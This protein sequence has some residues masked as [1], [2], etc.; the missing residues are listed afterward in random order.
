MT[1]A[2]ISTGQPLPPFEQP[3]SAA[4]SQA[5]A[6][7]IDRH[8]RQR[9]RTAFLLVAPL[10]VFLLVA[11]FAPIGSML[12]RS[13]YSP[14]VHNLI[15]QTLDRLAAWDQT[16][17]PPDAMLKT[18]A[19]ELKALAQQRQEGELGAAINQ[20]S[21]GAASLF[22]MTG[23]RIR[24]VDVGAMPDAQASQWLRDV[25]PDW[26]DTALWQA[27]AEA[28]NTYTARNYLKAAGFDFKNGA[29]TRSDTAAI[30]QTLYLKTLGIAFSITVLCIVL[31]YPLAYYLA[32]A[33]SKTANALMILVL[34]PFWTSL[35]VRTTSWIALLQTDGVVNTV[36]LRLGLIDAPLDLLYT[37]FAT[38]IAMTHILLPFMILPLY[39]VMRGIDPSY[40]RAAVSMGSTPLRAFFRVFFPLTL[41]GLSAGTLLV[42]IISVGYYITP[43]LVGGSDGQMISNVI[44]F[45]IQSTNNWGLA[46]ALGSILLAII[47]LLYW[48]YDRLVGAG[49]LKLG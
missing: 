33:P 28:G 15:P 13:V 41:A 8:L 44:A 29:F 16:A 47:L 17:P 39:S 10:L 23:R 9:R 31:G 11:F 18:F 12:F 42:F 40:M 30:Y 37:R 1:R 32:K 25:N 46:A 48:V 27:V 43:A 34:L 6:R 49:N 3:A 4:L 21:P 2:S 26:H 45:N 14:T 24:G 36:L 7:G 38:V 20:V 35:L 19:V 5:E 22:K